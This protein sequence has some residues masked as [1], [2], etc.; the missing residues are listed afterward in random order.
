MNLTELNIYFCCISF[1]F[2]FHPSTFYT[3]LIHFSC[4]WARG[5]VHPGQ[6]AS[7]LKMPHRDQQPHTH[8]LT[9]RVNSESPIN[10]TCM[11]LTGGRKPEYPERT[12]TY[13]GR[14]Q[15]HELPYC[16]VTVLTTTPPC[17]PNVIYHAVN[18]VVNAFNTNKH[19]CSESVVII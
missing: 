18:F 2:D 17:S 9:P 3:H 12:H 15:N 16:E 10:L 19:Q 1:T 7:P 6:V 13:T 14:T 4:H 8:T 5:G 11:F